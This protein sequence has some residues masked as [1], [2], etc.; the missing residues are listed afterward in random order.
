[1]NKIIT[2]ILRPI[3]SYLNKGRFIFRRVTPKSNVQEL[4]KTLRPFETNCQ[5]IRLGPNG[6]GGYL[7]PD[8]LVG[9]EAC[10]SPGV[11]K[12]SN[13][14]LDCLHLGMKIFMADKSVEKPNLDIPE[15]DYNFLKKFI[16]CTNNND[17]I[18]ME[19]WVNSS[20]IGDQSD[21]L[22][23]MDI[24][25]GEYNTVINMSDELMKRF[26]IMVFEFHSLQDVWQLRFFDF[27]SMTFNKILQ[28][29]T[30]VHIHPN[31]EDGVENRLGITIPRTIEFTFLR[32]DRI[33]SK[34]PSTQFPHPL[35]S[36]NS[37]KA[38]VPLPSQWY[39]N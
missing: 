1:M 38:H 18:T 39:K 27:V 37:K 28:T 31:N 21:L 13:F 22:L 2:S 9:I 5:L 16:G 25:G 36:D 11:Y 34:K 33:I 6:D 32:N 17:F 12:V 30:C 10:F 26:R 19:S 7:I 15:T 24:E 29:H 4:I 3:E 35:D 23:Q 8:D 14:E 20:S